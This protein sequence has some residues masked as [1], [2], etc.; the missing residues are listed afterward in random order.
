MDAQIEQVDDF[1]ARFALGGQLHNLAFSWRRQF[2][3]IHSCAPN[4]KFLVEAAPAVS[5]SSYRTSITE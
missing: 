3:R 4:A 2:V 5:R 1:L